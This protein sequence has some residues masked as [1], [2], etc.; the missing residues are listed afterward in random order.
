MNILQEEDDASG[1]PKRES[2]SQEV[3]APS[4]IPPNFGGCTQMMTFINV[5]LL[6]WWGKGVTSLHTIK[7]ICNLIKAIQL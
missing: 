2:S 7:E 3:S 4:S 6:L 1:A 5:T